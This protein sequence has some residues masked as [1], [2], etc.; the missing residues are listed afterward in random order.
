MLEEGLFGIIIGIITAIGVTFILSFIFI[1]PMTY[2][3]INDTWERESIHRGY[4]EYCS[5]RTFA[6]VGECNE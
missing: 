4:G 3:E 6:W 2:S 1:V 5:N